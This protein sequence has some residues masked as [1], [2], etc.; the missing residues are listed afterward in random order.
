MAQAGK[1]QLSG[2]DVTR[3]AIRAG[4]KGE[5]LTLAVAIAKAESQ[6]KRDTISTTNDYGLW[7]INQPS[8]PSHDY[9]RMLVDADYAATVA[10]TISGGGSKAGWNQWHTY[11][12]V[13]KPSG[14]GPYRQYLNEAVAVVTEVTSG[15]FGDVPSNP[16]NM[17]TT[18][19]TM[20]APPK[21]VTFNEPV[22]D[23]DAYEEQAQFDERHRRVGTRSKLMSIF[24]GPTYTGLIEPLAPALAGPGNSKYVYTGNIRT[25]VGDV[26]R[27][28]KYALFFEFNPNEISFSYSANPN[29]LPQGS[30]DPSQTHTDIPMADSNTVMSFSLLFDRTYEV[31]NGSQVGVLTDVRTLEHMT[32]ITDAEPVMRQN[33]VAIHFGTPVQ[34]HYKALIQSFSVVYQHFSHAMVPMRAA[35]SVSATRLSNIDVWAKDKETVEKY[36]GENWRDKIIEANAETVWKGP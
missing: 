33:P 9:T 5:G 14:T 1:I 8:H 13:D 2:Q 19:T 10:F 34:F 25:L 15:V 11:T 3:S 29:V 4:F 21:A 23:W 18:G 36:T 30:L 28:S 20:P 24:A 7:Q 12:P 32:G 26:S 22:I 31:M 35:V 27:Y 16:S 6:W 17:T